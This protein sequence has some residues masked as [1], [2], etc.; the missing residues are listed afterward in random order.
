MSDFTYKETSSTL[1]SSLIHDLVLV[2]IGTGM[3]SFLIAG[4]IASKMELNG[5]SKILAFGLAGVA[6]LLF[7]F[8]MALYDIKQWRRIRDKK[9]RMSKIFSTLMP[10]VCRIENCALFAEHKTTSGELYRSENTFYAK[11]YDKSGVRRSHVKAAKHGMHYV[12]DITL[13]GDSQGEFVR[14]V[15]SDYDAPIGYYIRAVEYRDQVYIESVNDRP[16]VYEDK[17]LCSASSS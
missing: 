10:I 13:R 8:L 4:A 14:V 6:V 17:E 1:T 3:F 2:F 9:A 11:R 12:F 16:L 15:Q 5:V 7:C